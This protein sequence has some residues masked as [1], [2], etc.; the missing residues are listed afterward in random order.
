MISPLNM[1]H[2]RNF[3]MKKNQ[4]VRMVIVGKNHTQTWVKILNRFTSKQDVKN[5]TQSRETKRNRLTSKQGVKKY[6]Y[7]SHIGRNG[8]IFPPVEQL[9]RVCKMVLVSR[10]KNIRLKVIIIKSSIYQIC[11][12]SCFALEMSP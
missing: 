1:L 9:I 10:A 11:L 12:L 4:W 6:K 3:K 2:T 8:G 5:H 7:F